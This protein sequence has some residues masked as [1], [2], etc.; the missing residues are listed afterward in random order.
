MVQ[1][2]ER[3][4]RAFG[5]RQTPYLSVTRMGPGFRAALMA[6]SAWYRLAA[7]R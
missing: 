3:F 4:F 2:I 6:R 7:R 1:P 5:A